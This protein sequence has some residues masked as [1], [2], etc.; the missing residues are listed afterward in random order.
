[1]TWPTA[2]VVA[3]FS[4]S[5]RDSAI[6]AVVLTAGILEIAR[7]QILLRVRGLQPVVAILGSWIAVSLAIMAATWLARRR[8]GDADSPVAEK[9]RPQRGRPVGLVLAFLLGVTVG[10]IVSV[11]C[12]P[13]PAAIGRPHLA[14]GGALGSVSAAC[15][16]A[17]W[18]ALSD[19][20]T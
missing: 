9:M 15:M 13:L 20:A 5:L 10:L 6:L 17:A 3:W 16:V 2:L 12:I 19:G 14:C 1:M 4:R 7:F 18:G 8:T 11:G